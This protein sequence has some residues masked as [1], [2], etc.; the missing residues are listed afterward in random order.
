M[1]IEGNTQTTDRDTI[2]APATAPGRAAVA[3]VRLSGPRSGDALLAIAG[4]ARNMLPP[5]REAVFRRLRDPAT[6]DAID[7]ALVLWLPGPRSETGEDM[8][9]LQFHGGRAI[10]AAVLAVLARI[11]GLG[12]AEPGEFARR[13]FDNGKLDLTAIEALGDLIAA[14][15]TKNH[16]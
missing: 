13:A 16:E 8:A 3:V 12:L 5:P 11:D 7:E 2:Y 6:N 4:G 15:R 14:R 1:A 10:M 9:E